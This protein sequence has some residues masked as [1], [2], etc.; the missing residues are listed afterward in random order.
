MDNAWVHTSTCRR[1]SRSTHTPA[2]G[3]SRKV[4]I[5][6]AKPTLPNKGG[7][8]GEPVDQPAGGHARHPR[9][10]Q[11]D[12]LAAK[13]K[14]EVAMAQ[15]APCMRDAGGHAQLHFGGGLGRVH[16]PYWVRI[17][18]NNCFLIRSYFFG[19]RVSPKSS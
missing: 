10:D 15:R 11:R 16:A 17:T 4:G 14:P 5:C 6:P 12:G 3:A 18:H 19:R 1:S 7:G 8:P 9:A 2:K 13:E